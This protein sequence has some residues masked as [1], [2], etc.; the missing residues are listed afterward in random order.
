MEL[1]TL[2]D[3]RQRLRRGPDLNYNKTATSVP[4]LWLLRSDTLSWRMVSDMQI[5]QMGRF[6]SVWSRHSYRTYSV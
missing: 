1:I 6:S 5:C 3:S 2:L 4:E